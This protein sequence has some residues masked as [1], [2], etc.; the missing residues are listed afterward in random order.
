MSEPPPVPASSTEFALGNLL[1]DD[2][3][4]IVPGPVLRVLRCDENGLLHIPLCSFEGGP[5]G[6]GHAFVDIERFGLR[7]LWRNF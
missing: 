6:R 3:L 2:L 5:S 1:A 7:S 4:Q